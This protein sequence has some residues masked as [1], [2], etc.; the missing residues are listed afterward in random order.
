MISSL[1]LRAQLLAAKLVWAAC[2]VGVVA[3]PT[4]WYVA[5]RGGSGWQTFD[6][7]LQVFGLIEAGTAAVLIQAN[8]RRKITGG[9]DSQGNR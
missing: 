4:A 1:L 2:I 3:V 5:V 7:L 6:M 9:S 8:V